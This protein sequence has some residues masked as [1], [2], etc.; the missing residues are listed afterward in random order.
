VTTG[1]NGKELKHSTISEYSTE[2]E[3]ILSMQEEDQ[4]L[5]KAGGDRTWIDVIQ[6]LEGL[7]E[8]RLNC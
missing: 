3:A 1:S 4:K 5:R 8:K 2:L 7:K 6:I